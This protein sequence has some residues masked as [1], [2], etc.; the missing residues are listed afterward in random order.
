M[1]L[2]TF[3]ASSCKASRI[4]ESTIRLHKS[5]LTTF[6]K[7]AVEKLNLEV[8]Q[9]VAIVQDEENPTD[10]YLVLDAE[11]GF[12]L[13]E[14]AN[15]ALMFCNAFIA[16]TIIDFMDVNTKSISF[17]LGKMIDHEGMKLSA[18]LIGSASY[19]EVD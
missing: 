13:R 17:K 15:G 10:W 12:A 1:K 6:T 11:N 7:T 5:G 16:K 14:Y 2:I 4:G 19:N 9:Q 18:I 3:D 8:G